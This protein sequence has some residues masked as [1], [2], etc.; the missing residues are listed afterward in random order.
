[1]AKKKKEVCEY[2]YFWDIETSHIITDQG[3]EMQITFLSNILKCNAL[4]GEIVQDIF[5]RTMAEVIEYFMN[6]KGIVWVHNLDYELYFL[7]REGQFNLNPEKT[8]LLRA[9]HAPLQLNFKELPNVTF[10]DTYALF[11]TSVEKLG[12]DVGS[13]KLDYD[14]KVV[15]CPWDEL[16]EHD[17]NYNRRDNEIVRASIFKYMAEH[18]YTIDEIPLTFTSQVRRSRKRFI[19]SEFGKKAINKFYFDRKKYY[20]DFN[21]FED[22]QK[23]Y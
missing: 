9:E 12:E 11:N 1:M 14:Y 23:V 7:L 18:G 22:M 19:S 3:S 20:D 5:H 4:T 10:R 6:E 21:F 8:N 13:P 15:R 16:T 2:T 17:Y